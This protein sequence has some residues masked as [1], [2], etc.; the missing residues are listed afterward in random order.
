MSTSRSS[1]SRGRH[2]VIGTPEDPRR[3]GWGCAGA[4]GAGQQ[5]GGRNPSVRSTL[6]GWVSHLTTQR[7]HW[8]GFLDP[9]IALLSSHPPLQSGTYYVCVLSLCKDAGTMKV[10]TVFVWEGGSH[11]AL[12][13]CFHT[14]NRDKSSL[15]VVKGSQLS[16]CKP[17]SSSLQCGEKKA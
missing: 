10:W 5:R 6:G 3:N 9:R 15:W 11:T 7:Q 13:L 2:T 1:L 12:A 8:A 17:P 16:T 4:H 14:E